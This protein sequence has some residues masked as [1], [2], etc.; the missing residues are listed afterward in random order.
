[1][2]HFRRPVR[3]ADVDAARLV[4]FSR[5][6]EYC[7]DALEGLFD[8]LP[9][10]Y[11]H[12]TAVRDIGIPTVHVEIA[13]KAPLRYGDVAAFEIDV[14]RVGRTSVTVQHTI[15]READA[16]VCAVVRHVFVTARLSGNQPVPV[17]DDLRALLATHLV[18]GHGDTEARRVI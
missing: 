15:R 11:P 14:L 16:T 4:F 5:F 7:H 2:F 10:G 8:A 9:G 18:E 3:F 13:Y 17:P 1:M 6:L 12:L